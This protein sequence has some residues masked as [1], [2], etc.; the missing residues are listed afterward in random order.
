MDIV[1]DKIDQALDWIWKR[2]YSRLEN[3]DSVRVFFVI[4][5]LIGIDARTS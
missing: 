5:G 4:L 2:K 3:E 1:K